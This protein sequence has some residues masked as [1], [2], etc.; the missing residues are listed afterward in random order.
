MAKPLRTQAGRSSNTHTHTTTLQTATAGHFH[1]LFQ[2]SVC[3]S[4]HHL[5]PLPYLLHFLPPPSPIPILFHH[6][7]LLFSSFFY[8]HFFFL[9]PP[10]PSPPPF[11]PLNSLLLTPLPFLYFSPI[12]PFLLST[13]FSFFTTLPPSFGS[14]DFGYGFSPFLLVL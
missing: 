6:V 3:F 10:P 9:P 7:Q 2:T 5:S 4:H 8:L 11:L 1:D 14:K 13:Y 12:P